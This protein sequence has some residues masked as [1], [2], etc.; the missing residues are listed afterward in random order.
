MPSLFKISNVPKRLD[1]NEATKELTRMNAAADGERSVR[2]SHL[3]G[4]EEAQTPTQPYNQLYITLAMRT[5]LVVW[6]TEVQG[7]FG[8]KDETLHLAVRVLDMFMAMCH[9]IPRRQFQL[10][11]TTAL[12]IASKYEE[13]EQLALKDLVWITNETYTA[14]QLI[15][16]ESLILSAIKYTLGIPSELY[17]LMCDEYTKEETRLA[18]YIVDIARAGSIDFVGIK[19]SE[20]ASAAMT[21][22]MSCL[23]EAS[24]EECWENVN[25]H[26]LPTRVFMDIVPCLEKLTEAIGC[27][28]ADKEMD[29]IRLKFSDVRAILN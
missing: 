20:L 17:F 3:V 12:M 8:L 25:Q 13:V 21:M 14:K 4:L 2:T 27:L 26:N 24:Y 29:P 5:I 28:R 18:H 22:A 23:T 15:D 1:S 19:S 6:L 9:D 7:R 11:G 16:Y 10:V